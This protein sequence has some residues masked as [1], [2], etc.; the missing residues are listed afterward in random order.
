[1]RFLIIALLFLSPSLALA[2]G[3][4]TES[5]FLSKSPVTEGDSVRIYAVVANPSTAKFSGQVDV[6]EGETKIGTAAVTMDAGGTQTISVLWKPLAGSHTV[7]E[8]LLSSEG[9]VVETK[10]KIFVINPKPTPPPKATGVQENL[11]SSSVAIESSQGIQDQINGVSPAAANVAAPVFSAI[12][13]LRGKVAGVA[14]EQLSKAKANVSDPSK[15]SWSIVW[16]LYI[17][18]LTLLKFIIGNVGV[19][20]P[21]LALIFFYI[22]WRVF[23]RIRRPS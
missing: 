15:S 13:S 21:I 3:F 18:L 6:K 17:Y 2:A 7:S 19:F 9:V 1:M 14:D 5:I 12:D 8:E 23:R 20:Y 22:L 16:T 10:S 4:A 11:S